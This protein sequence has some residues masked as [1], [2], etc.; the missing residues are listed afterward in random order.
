[1][2]GGGKDHGVGKVVV[3]VETAAQLMKLPVEIL[4]RSKHVRE[5][6]VTY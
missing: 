4:G 2:G 3:V 5:A 1:M 6:S